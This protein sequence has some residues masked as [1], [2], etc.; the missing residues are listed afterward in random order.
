MSVNFIPLQLINWWPPRRPNGIITKYIVFSE[1]H[2]STKEQKDKNFL[3]SESLNTKD[4]DCECVDVQPY[5]SGPQPD[6]EDY[7]NKEQIT[8]E[9]A[10]PNLIYVS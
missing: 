3:I 5:D 2:N 6:D 10:L 7:Y 9:D 4:L 1:K 8:Y